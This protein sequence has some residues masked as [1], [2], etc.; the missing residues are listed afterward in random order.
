MVTGD[1]IAVF[2]GETRFDKRFDLLV[3]GDRLLFRGE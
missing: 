2:N 3:D 1:W